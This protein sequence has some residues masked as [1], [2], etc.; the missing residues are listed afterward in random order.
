MH[1]SIGELAAQAGVKVE[2]VRFYEREGLLP[3]PPRAP[4][5]HRRY[6]EHEVRRLRFIRKARELGFTLAETRDLLALRATRGTGCGDVKRR[7]E[8]KIAD[9]EGRIRSLERMKRA[10]RRLHAACEG[11][12]VPIA[13]C[14]ILEALEGEFPE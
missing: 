13:D 6:R 4:S 1:L 3:E 2:T 12:D 9:I 8:E 7:A 11:G 14:P 10:L 5:G